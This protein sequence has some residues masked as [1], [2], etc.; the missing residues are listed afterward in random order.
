MKTIIVDIADLKVGDEITV[1]FGNEGYGQGGKVESLSPLSIRTPL[2]DVQAFE[3]WRR[4]DKEIPFRK[5]EC[6]SYED[7]YCA[8]EVDWAGKNPRC[9]AHASLYWAAMDRAREYMSPTPPSWFDE[10]Y[11]GERWSDDY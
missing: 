8:G 9:E 5:E 4:L 2:D 11:A 10:S 3:E 1:W 6:I 7:D